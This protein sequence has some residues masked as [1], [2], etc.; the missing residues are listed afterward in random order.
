MFTINVLG[1]HK[2][3][4]TSTEWSFPSEPKLAGSS[5]G[6]PSFDLNQNQFFMCHASF[7]SSSQHFKLDASRKHV[8]IGLSI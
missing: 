2:V 5:W 3:T 7:L 6:F 1:I 4:A 8:N